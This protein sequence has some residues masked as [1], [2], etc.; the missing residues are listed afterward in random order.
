MCAQTLLSND[1]RLAESIFEMWEKACAIASATNADVSMTKGQAAIVFGPLCV[2]SNYIN[3]SIHL[4]TFQ[5]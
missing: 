1:Q 2:F 3:G 5:T 4:K